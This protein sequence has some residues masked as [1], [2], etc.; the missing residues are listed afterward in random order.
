MKI[1]T[2]ELMSRLRAESIWAEIQRM[3]EEKVSVEEL[4]DAMF[5]HEEEIVRYV[6]QTLGDYQRKA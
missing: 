6:T 5:K 2:D 1:K 4:K 3:D